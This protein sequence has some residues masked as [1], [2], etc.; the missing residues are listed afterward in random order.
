VGGGCLPEITVSLLGYGLQGFLSAWLIC[1]YINPR[2]IRFVA[3][4]LVIHCFFLET[5]GGCDAGFE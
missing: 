5:I 4:M 1:I 3:I 2:F